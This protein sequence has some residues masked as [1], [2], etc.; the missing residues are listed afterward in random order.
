MKIDVTTIAGFEAMT[1]AEKVQALLNVDM[2]D[3]SAELEKLKKAT[4]KA[5]AEAADW[6]R[7]YQEA[8]GKSKELADQS[9]E[10]LD[11]LREQVKQLT[12][13]SKVAEYKAGF[14]AQGYSEKLAAETASALYDGDHAKVLENGMKFRDNLAQ[15]L[16]A[17][18]M[19]GTPRPDMGAENNTVT[20]DAFRKMSMAERYAYAKDHPDEYREMYG[21]NQ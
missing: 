12:R 1:D 6:K 21:G 8:N 19:K 10:E 3:N 16:K 4:S 15:K 13:D 20:K 17:D 11:N 2:D 18:A 7:R 5:N 14:I 9:N